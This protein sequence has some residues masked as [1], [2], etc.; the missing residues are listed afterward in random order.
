VSEKRALCEAIR[1]TLRQAVE[2]G[3]RDTERDL[4]DR[5]GRYRRILD[6][7]S[8]GQPCPEC[9]TWIE[10]IQY[11]GGASYVCPRCQT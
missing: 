10:K 11:L 7:R 1:G 6:A 9:G 5:P 2:L 8:V 3:G 4:Y